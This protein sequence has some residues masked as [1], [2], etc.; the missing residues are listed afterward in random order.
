MTKRP[1]CYRTKKTNFKI[2]PSIERLFWIRRAAFSHIRRK[3]CLLSSRIALIV[4]NWWGNSRS[5]ESAFRKCV[6]YIFILSSF[7]DIISKWLSVFQVFASCCLCLLVQLIVFT[8]IAIKM[9]LFSMKEH[10]SKQKRYGERFNT[11]KRNERTNSN[12]NR[13]RLRLL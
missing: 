3:S 2:L 12:N 9:L 10:K 6:V 5:I 13:K 8:F 1:L 7:V 11:H 4:L